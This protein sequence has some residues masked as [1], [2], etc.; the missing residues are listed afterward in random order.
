MQRKIYVKQISTCLERNVIQYGPK[1]VKNPPICI[2]MFI[3]QASFPNVAL[4]KR[5][6][7]GNVKS[8]VI[9]KFC[10]CVS[11]TRRT[12]RKGYLRN[13]TEEILTMLKSTAKGA[14]FTS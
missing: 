10:I 1:N 12:Y 13:L 9:S 4:V 2:K 11:K 5:S 3:N 7:D 14:F 6:I 8:N